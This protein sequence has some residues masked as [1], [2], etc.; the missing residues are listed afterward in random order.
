MIA[1][2]TGPTPAWQKT[3]LFAAVGA[4]GFAAL[5]WMDAGHRLIDDAANKFYVD[6]EGAEGAVHR[7]ALY[8][9]EERGLARVTET[10]ADGAIR[11]V[12]I[13]EKGREALVL[14]REQ[15]WA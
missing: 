8:E 12:E 10:A 5:E 2:W 3:E 13:T 14:P 6:T 4:L 15:K 7:G 9:L 11:Y 1:Y